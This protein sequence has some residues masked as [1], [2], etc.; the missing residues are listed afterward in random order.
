MVFSV[1][2]KGSVNSRPTEKLK[3]PRRLIHEMSE[4]AS[5]NWP[6][7]QRKARSDVMSDRAFRFRLWFRFDS[8]EFRQ[9]ALSFDVFG[10]AK[11]PLTLTGVG[12]TKSCDYLGEVFEVTAPLPTGRPALTLRSMVPLTS[13]SPSKYS[14][15]PRLGSASSKSAGKSDALHTRAGWVQTE[16]VLGLP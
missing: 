16:P 6:S 13:S 3:H 12:E 10:H 1:A 4:T 8:V 2:R 14:W 11:A 7:E 5:W 15:L 9:V